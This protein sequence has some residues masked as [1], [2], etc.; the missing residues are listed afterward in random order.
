MAGVLRKTMVYLGLMEHDD[1]EYDDDL[2]P[3][4]EPA[5]PSVRRLGA[6]ET[7][8]RRDTATEQHGA[9]ALRTRVA[10][11]AFTEPPPPYR[12]T[13]FCPANYNDARAIGEHYRKG[14]P[15]IMNVSDMDERDAKRLVDFAAGLTFGLHGQLEKV[16]N[17]V[18][19]LSPSNIEVSA[20]DKARI[21]EG[22]FF[23]QS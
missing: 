12:I 16:T 7:R 23:N 5:P 14:V 22:G 17:R 18:F 9:L 21:R 11:E 1:E 4:S 6:E 19:L 20:E 2:L 8:G 13:T 10:E 15:V 3:E